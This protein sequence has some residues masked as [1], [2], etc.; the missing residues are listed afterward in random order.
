MEP[1]AHWVIMGARRGIGSSAAWRLNE[2][3]IAPCGRHSAFVP[4]S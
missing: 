3:D 4:V 2:A 1:M